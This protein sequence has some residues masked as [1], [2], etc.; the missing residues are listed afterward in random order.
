MKAKD[1]IE[2]LKAV[3]PEAQVLIAGYDR[4]SGRTILQ[5]T[6]RCCNDEHQNK[7]GQFWLSAE[8]IEHEESRR[9]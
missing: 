6:H 9:A 5:Y 7:L 2:A 3:D 4:K 1:L 8:G